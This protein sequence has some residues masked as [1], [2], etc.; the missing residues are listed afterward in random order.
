M[1][2]IMNETRK[3]GFLD[4][5][6]KWNNSFSTDRKE[7]VTNV[8]VAGSFDLPKSRYKVKS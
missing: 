8:D 2:C 3:V 4:D 6:G 7:Q 5:I 1:K